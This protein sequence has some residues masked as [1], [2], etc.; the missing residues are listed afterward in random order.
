[1][2]T[3]VS[4]L[5]ISLVIVLLPWLL[6]RIRPVRRIAPLAVVQILVGVVLG[7]SG[8][9]QIAPDHA[10]L[11]SRPVLAAVDGVSSLG[12]LLY[13]FITGLHL[14][15]APLR[16]DG[17]KLGGIAIG[18][19]AVPLLAGCGGGA[20]MLHAVPGALG[21]IGNGTVF[22]AAVA[23]CIAVTA[24]PVLAAVLQEMGLL[25]SRIG[26]TALALAAVNDAALWVMLAVLLA[27]ARSQ[28]GEGALLALGAALLWFGLMLT[29]VRRLLV[30]LASAGDQAV[31]VT[32]T[33]LAIL[34]ACVSEVL[35]TGYLIGAFTAGAIIP[36]TCRPALLRRLEMVTATVLLPFFFMSTGLKA[37]IQPGS[38]SFLGLTAVAVAATVLGKLAGTA[39]P[40]RRSG[41]SWPESM[42]LSAMMQTKGLMEVVV[43]AV[44]HDAGLIGA[45][46]FSAMVAMAVI[47]TVLTAPS[48]RLCQRLA[49]RDEPGAGIA[50]RTEGAWSG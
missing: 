7:P 10:A 9:G 4:L 39:L 26:Q 35:G 28:G 38:A 30:R 2:S 1:L 13:V 5:A 44:L 48:V 41:F 19:I 23:I 40:A 14:D 43:L 37:L 18:S 31:L 21:P 47:C 16:Q 42:A 46:I 25:R 11:F 22:V 3:K 49:V 17:R 29:V 6:W 24:L 32:A 45:Q 12:V 50:G 36:V 15:A 34:S 33:A 27:L 8:L 20:W